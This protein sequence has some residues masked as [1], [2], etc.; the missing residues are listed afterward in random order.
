MPSQALKGKAKK[1]FEEAL[2]IATEANDL[3]GQSR[4]QLGLS[5]LQEASGKLDVAVRIQRFAV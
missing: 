4:V 1:H 3:E 5:N 2:K